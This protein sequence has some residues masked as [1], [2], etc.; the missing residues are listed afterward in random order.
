MS[1]K[2]IRT[3]DGALVK[4]NGLIVGVDV[5]VIGLQQSAQFNGIQGTV[6]DYNTETERWTVELWQDESCSHRR[7]AV[8]SINVRRVESIATKTIHIQ[9][10]TQSTGFNGCV[11]KCQ[12]YDTVSDRW[13]V[14]TSGKKTQNEHTTALA[15]RP[16]CLVLSRKRNE[17]TNDQIE[18]VTFSKYKKT[19]RDNFVAR[20]LFCTINY[21]DETSECIARDIQRLK[22]VVAL[23]IAAGRERGRKN[24][25][26]HI[27]IAVVFTRPQ[28]RNTVCEMFGGRAN[29]Q[30]MYGN[31]QQARQYC[32]KNGDVLRDEDHGHQGRRT[33]IEAFVREIQKG[34]SDKYLVDNYPVQFTKW[35]RNIPYIRGTIEQL[36]LPANTK[37]TIGVWLHG[38]PGCGKSFLANLLYPNNYPKN[39]DKWWAFYAYQMVVLLDDPHP[40][41][42]KEL[43]AKIKVW[44]NE[45]VFIDEVKGANLKIRF[46]HLIV[47]SNQSPEDYFG[48]HFEK[49]AFEDRFT[50][51]A[52]QTRTELDAIKK[53]MPVNPSNV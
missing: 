25:V 14:A 35:C 22:H 37:R 50:T 12:R 30:Q 10:L 53:K 20:S 11:V 33:D 5:V 38:P 1:K 32:L 40:D 46:R 13:I 43:M 15:V 34:K 36:P 51:F 8:K 42:N 3:D 16:E 23:R 17:P 31:Y 7:I 4:T 52:V 48:V 18:R 6:V 27:H 39:S 28:R 24:G 41:F 26:L 45:Y 49:T 47:L 9:N 19:I 21:A 44:C 2:R 29:V